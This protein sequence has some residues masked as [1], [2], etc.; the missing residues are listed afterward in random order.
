MLNI[1]SSGLTVHDTVFLDVWQNKFIKF[2]KQRGNS[3]ARMIEKSEM[4]LFPQVAT[5]LRGELR[6][7]PKI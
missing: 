6:S 5:G 3:F 2:S 7:L 1:R 4:E